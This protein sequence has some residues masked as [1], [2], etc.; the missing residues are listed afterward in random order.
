MHDKPAE[1]KIVDIVK[2]TSDLQDKAVKVKLG[3]KHFHRGIVVGEDRVF[4]DTIVVGVIESTL[5]PGK[6]PANKYLSFFR[7][8]RKQLAII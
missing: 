1:D 3:G 4:K 2:T 8:K 7:A 5:M 6:K